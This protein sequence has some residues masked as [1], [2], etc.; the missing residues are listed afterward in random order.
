MLEFRCDPGTG[1][2][3]YSI[4]GGATW[5]N[6]PDCFIGPAGPTGATGAPG[7]ASIW[8][9]SGCNLQYSNDAGVTW[10]TASGWSIPAVQSCLIGPPTFPPGTSTAQGACNAAAYLA[11]LVIKGAINQAVSGYTG[12]ATTYNTIVAIVGLFD[13]VA[14]VIDLILAAGD[15]LVNA[16]TALTI[17]E[18]NTALADAA[19]W[20]LV[21]CTIYL[22]IVADGAVDS[23]NFAAVATALAG[24]G[25]AYPDVDAA[26]AAY[27]NALGLN[28]VLQAQQ[29]GAYY[30]GDCSACGTWCYQYAYGTSAYTAT[31]YD[32]GLTVWSPPNGWLGLYNAAGAPPNT[33]TGIEVPFSGTVISGLKVECRVPN[34][35]DSSISSVIIRRAGLSDITYHPALGGSGAVQ[36]L[37]YSFPAQPVDTL[38]IVLRGDGNQTNQYIYAIEVSGAGSNPLGADNCTF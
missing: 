31:S 13:W 25:S 1:L 5:T 26:I 24:M 32:P 37:S 30:A 35:T 18:Y 7:P 28:S 23:S 9:L 38:Y 36:Y 27:W 10:T 34:G 33:E 29:Q 20:A 2:P 8:R 11:A 15:I 6:L 17:S 14:P 4:D 22:A 12:G 19:Y 3:Q 21:Q 16:V